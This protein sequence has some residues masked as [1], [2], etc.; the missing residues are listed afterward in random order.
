MFWMILS[1]FP[2]IFCLFCSV[3]DGKSCFRVRKS[4]LTSE[5]HTEHPFAGRNKQ[6]V[7]FLRNKRLLIGVVFLFHFRL[8]MFNIVV[9]YYWALNFLSW[10]RI[11]NCL[12]MSP[13]LIWNSSSLLFTDHWGHRGQ[14]SFFG[15]LLALKSLLTE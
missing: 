3:S 11:K 12:Y 13:I 9:F 4:T 14:C 2:L 7:T 6:Q 8:Q 5:R 1:G 10:E 15:L